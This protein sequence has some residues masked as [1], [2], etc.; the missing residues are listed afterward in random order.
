MLTFKSPPPYAMLWKYHATVL[1]LTWITTVGS[2]LPWVTF[3]RQL[4]NLEPHECGNTC[5]FSNFF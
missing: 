3:H 4:S 5:F 2:L 1:W